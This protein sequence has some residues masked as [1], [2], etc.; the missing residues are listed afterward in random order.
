M[1]LSAHIDM[2][3]SPQMSDSNGHTAFK[4]S[5][6]PYND[7]NAEV[8]VAVVDEKAARAGFAHDGLLPPADSYNPHF[9]HG[10]AAHHKG[11]AAFFRGD[12]GS[13]IMTPFEKKAALI[14]RYVLLY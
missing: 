12:L 10:D 14:N 8:D 3:L 1:P 2:G 4:P 13:E 7:K 5:G 9:N 6:Y 11:A